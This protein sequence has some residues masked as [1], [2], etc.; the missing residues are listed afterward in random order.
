MLSSAPRHVTRAQSND[1]LPI[2]RLDIEQHVTDRK[3]RMQHST[4]YREGERDEVKVKHFFGGLLRGSC[5]LWNIIFFSL[6]WLHVCKKSSVPRAESCQVGTV[7]ISINY[8]IQLGPWFRW[9]PQFGQASMHAFTLFVDSYT[10][11]SLLKQVFSSVIDGKL[12]LQ[13]H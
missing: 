1:A 12:T 13:P 7:R 10:F 6:A 11:F 4:D 2:T 8:P 5:L 9:W 3:S